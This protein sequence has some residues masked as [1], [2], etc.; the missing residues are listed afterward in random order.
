MAVSERWRF[1]GQM[2][3]AYASTLEQGAAQKETDVR[4][5]DSMTWSFYGDSKYFMP[6]IRSRSSWGACGPPGRPVGSRFRRCSPRSPDK[7]STTP[8]T[9]HCHGQSG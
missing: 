7:Q 8:S 9:G 4:P 5:E 6:S 3:Y 1:P 2:P